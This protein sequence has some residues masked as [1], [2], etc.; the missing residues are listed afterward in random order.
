MTSRRRSNREPAIW[1][2]PILGTMDRPQVFKRGQVFVSWRVVSGILLLVLIGAL[3]V[4]F[5][6]DNFYVRGIAVGGL[7]TM[8]VNEVYA[9]LHVDGLHVFW[10][11]PDTIRADLLQS[12]TI[13]NATVSVGFPPNAIQ[14]IVEE[15]E[16][17]LVWEQAGVASWIDLQG[18]VMRQREDRQ[19]LLRIQTDPLIDGSIGVSID[20]LIVTSAIQLRDLLPNVPAFRYHP[21]KGLGYNDPGGWEVWFG[22]GLDMQQKFLIYN[23]IVADNAAQGTVPTEINLVNTH[24]PF[25]SMRAG[26]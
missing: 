9:L 25:V 18:R 26:Q 22:I 13:A 12:P 16:P 6:S 15:R 4:F 14:I 17:A 8:T 2:N 1:R 19:T 10:L 21:D 23:A 11:D 7:D 3:A 24:R 5:F 20:P